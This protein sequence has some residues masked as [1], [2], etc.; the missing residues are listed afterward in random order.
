MTHTAI[1]EDFI[2]YVSLNVLGMI[3][4]SCYIL[5]DTF[6]IS[7]SLG[8]LGLAALN[9]AIPAY[10]IINGIG[11]MAGMGGGAKFTI[12]KSQ[13]EP[14]QA[15]MVFTHSIVFGVAGGIIIA[16]IG[17][18]F[19]S[20]ISTLLGADQSTLAITDIYLK[21]ILCF[22]PFFILNNILLAYVRNDYNPKL[23]MI[24]MLTGSF[25]NIIL[26][27]VFIYPCNL[28]MFGAAFATGLSP[29]ISLAILSLHFTMHK[30][31]FHFKKSSII[32]AY[33]FSILSL[34]IAAFITELSSGVVLITFNLVISQIEGNIGVAAY[35]I[36]ANLALVII[37]IF[38]GISQGIQPL[39]SNNYALKEHNNVKQLLKYAI[40]TAI[41][42][43]GFVYTFSLIHSDFLIGVFNSERNV[44]LHDLASSGIQLYFAGFFC[45][46]F[47]IVSTTFF[48]AV[49]SPK[50][51]FVISV[52]RGFAAIIPMVFIFAMLLGIKGVWI[53]FPAAE[54]TTAM[55]A[56]LFLIWYHQANKNKQKVL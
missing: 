21:T 52:V 23:S 48:S 29:I 55:L 4:L 12:L 3:G 5:A 7:K 53:S 26:D 6:F 47:N 13:N 31:Q 1:K 38:T 27:Y 35:G 42:F 19:S 15:N 30:N 54:G 32:P 18:L 43:S 36:I 37:A 46:G 49:E 8:S 50:Q 16:L 20:P 2:K 17:L 40:I 25:S 34:G 33:I 45:A 24:A 39:L 14:E 11:L 22:A 56:L 41:T 44:R 10:N 28:G 9:F 51:S